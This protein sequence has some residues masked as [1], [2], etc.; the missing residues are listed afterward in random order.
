MKDNENAL[1]KMQEY[2]SS[3]G[4]QLFESGYEY[5]CDITWKQW[6]W[7]VI[8]MENRERRR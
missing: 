1:N 3:N 4:K 2:K 5:C 6:L 8:F 7:Q